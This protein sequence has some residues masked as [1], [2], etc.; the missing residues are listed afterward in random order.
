MERL[1]LERFRSGGCAFEG[2]A[3]AIGFQPAVFAIGLIAEDRR[4]DVSHV[5]ADLV[6]AAGFE[7]ALDKSGGGLRA[8]VVETPEGFET[9]IVGDCDLAGC[10]STFAIGGVVRPVVGAEVLVFHDRHLLTVI[11]RAADVRLDATDQ[12]TRRAAR[13][14]QV[15]AFDVVGGEHVGEGGV[16]RFALGGDHDAGRIL[17]EAVDDAGPSDAADAGE[18]LAAMKE[19]GVDQRA[20]LGA[21]G[22]VDDEAGRLVDDDEVF[23]LED[24]IERDV[25]RFGQRADGDGQVDGLDGAGD[26][27]GAGVGRRLAVGGDAAFLDQYPQAGPGHA[28]SRVSQPFIEARARCFRRGG[29]D[30][31]LGLLGRHAFVAVR[32]K[33]GIRKGH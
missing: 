33:V 7:A 14:G 8:R 2:G 31:G 22:R 12:W 25:F 10:L 13:D 16:G 21:A 19:Q 6:C 28:G 17:V 20:A 1:P 26:D 32:C 29:N 24:D 11:G 3:F 4:A 23:V 5:D 27:F 9:T 30:H 18:S 15:G